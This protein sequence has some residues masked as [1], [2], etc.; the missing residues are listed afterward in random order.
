MKNTY[1]RFISFLEYAENGCWT[2]KG[3]INPSGYGLFLFQGKLRLAHRVSWEL[4]YGFSPERN[5]VICH[6]CDNRSCVNPEHLF[7]GT[8]KDNA[9]DKMKKGRHVQ[10]YG[11]RK[12]TIDDVIK[13]RDMYMTGT[14]FQKDLAEMFGV[15]HSA[16][17][18]ILRL[19]K[20][21][22]IE[23]P[24]INKD[25][26]NEVRISRKISNFKRAYK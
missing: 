16:I 19:S 9:R 25:R 1:E 7:L 13:I 20:W 15:G 24:A 3:S 12:L 10:A 8:D 14:Y 22:G 21:C 11:N 6:T 5:V 18:K 4:V 26:F 23:L 17:D 2:W